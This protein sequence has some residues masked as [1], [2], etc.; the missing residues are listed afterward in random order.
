MEFVNRDGIDEF[1]PRETFPRVSN[2]VTVRATRNADRYDSSCGRFRVVVTVDRHNLPSFEERHTG[3]VRDFVRWFS[4]GTRSRTTL[5]C[6]T[7]VALGA[8]LRGTNA[9]T[10]TDAEADVPTGVATV[11]SDRPH[12]NDDLFRPREVDECEPFLCDEAVDTAVDGFLERFDFT[13][14]EASPY[15]V[16]VTVAEAVLV[17]V[18]EADLELDLGDVR[19]QGDLFEQVGT[20]PGEAVELDDVSEDRGRID[21]VVMGEWIWM[22]EAM[23]RDVYEALVRLIGDRIERSESVWVTSPVDTVRRRGGREPTPHVAMRSRKRTT[24]K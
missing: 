15:D 1:G 8:A 10:R 23:Q 4:S 11:L 13:V 17:P 16:D 19:L 3:Y 14:S 21:E 20:K 7:G 12:V 18:P 2:E 24:T 6:S 22:D 9:P 5:A